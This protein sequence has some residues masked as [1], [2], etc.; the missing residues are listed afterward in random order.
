MHDPKVR[1]FDLNPCMRSQPFFVDVTHQTLYILLLHLH[2]DGSAVVCWGSNTAY[3]RG[4]QQLCAPQS[5]KTDV[6]AFCIV[7][8]PCITQQGAMSCAAGIPEWASLS[9]AELILQGVEAPYRALAV[10]TGHMH[11]CVILEGGQI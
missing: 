5:P 1:A 10:C 9:G 4:R 7:G 2:S 6:P 3:Q 8:L 11:T